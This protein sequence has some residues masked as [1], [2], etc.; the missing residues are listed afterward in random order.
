M[1]RFA[2]IAVFTVEGFHRWPDA[3]APVEFLRQ[4]HRHLFHVELS[5]WVTHA[6]RDIEIL[7]LRRRGIEVLCGEYGLP[8]EFGSLSCEHIADFLLRA[9]NLSRCKVLEDGENGAVAYDVHPS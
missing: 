8:C 6:D 4:R 5:R 1:P 9:L 3:P 2:V 7:M